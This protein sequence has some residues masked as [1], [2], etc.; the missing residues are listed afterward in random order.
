MEEEGEQFG[1]GEG[2]LIL[3]HMYHFF[4]FGG[5]KSIGLGFGAKLSK[6]NP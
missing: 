1:K 6:F 3:P 5:G 4:S 2:R